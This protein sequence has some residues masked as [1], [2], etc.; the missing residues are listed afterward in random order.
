MKPVNKNIAQ[1]I[2]FLAAGFAHVSAQT[3]QVPDKMN[4]A[5]SLSFDFILKEVIATHPTVVKATEAIQLAEAGIG[6]AKSAHL[7][8]I[9]FGTG[10]T[11]IGPVPA[12]S[13]PGM[14]SFDMAPADNFNA[15]VGVR[16]TVYDFSKTAKDIQL[17]ESTKDMATANVDL[18][19]QRLALVTAANYYVLVYLQEAI[20]IKNQQI[21]ILKQ[22]LDFVNKK[23]ETGS[24]TKYEVLSTKVRL[25]AA[26]T[27]KVDIETSYT[28]ALT[29]LNSLLGLPSETRLMV[30]FTPLNP[31]EPETGEKMVDF[32]YNH[33]ADMI[34]ANLK[35]QHAELNLAAVKVQN[36]PVIS[37]FTSGGFKNGYFPDLYSM[38]ANY[39]AGLTLRV[40][41]Y[42]ASR[43]KY[44]VMMANTDINMAQQDQQL[45]RRDISTEVYQ[46]DANMQAAY[47]KIEQS[48]MQVQQAE[49]ARMLAE[50]SFKTGSI[51]NL[52]LFDAETLESESRLSL[53]KA[54][55]E[56]NVSLFRL[57]ISMGRPIF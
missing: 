35:Q 52:D 38:K 36:N 51:T 44:H 47:R 22:H 48:E 23:F 16:E 4:V 40:P 53:L 34:L 10:Y 19:K 17:R 13:V 1:L 55:T 26:E 5:D 15:A 14:G 20:K 46:S 28:N 11:R 25:S 24:T 54:R 39:T 30:R 45:T 7:P 6:L 18:V 8:D 2:L 42:T 31:L 57:N 12:I 9:D 21:D 49:E 33:R 50:V 43:Q 27:Q 37:A 3:N 41:I 56:Y 32:A 29:S